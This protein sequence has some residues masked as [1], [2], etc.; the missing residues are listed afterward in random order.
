MAERKINGGGGGGRVKNRP[1]GWSSCKRFFF[2]FFCSEGA[3][4]SGFISGG[5]APPPT[6]P[7][8]SEQPGERR[9][10]GRR[11]NPGGVSAR[12]EG[13]R[14]V[15]Q[16]EDFSSAVLLSE[17]SRHGGF[18]PF[19]SCNTTFVAQFCHENTIYGNYHTFLLECIG[20]YVS[21]M[22]DGYIFDMTLLTSASII[23]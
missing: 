3:A 11:G 17:Q 12:A 18:K 2:F 4:K 20:Y 1:P 22:L 16:M 7:S 8:H 10:V 19:V 9:R 5:L 6:A 21:E 23:S 13:G 14:Q 15:E